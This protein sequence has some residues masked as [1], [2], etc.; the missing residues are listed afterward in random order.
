VLDLLVI[1]IV[2]ALA[3]MVVMWYGSLFA[4]SYLYT[5]PV[6]GISWRAPAA[7]GILTGFYLVWS[8]ANIWGATK[9]SV[10]VTEVPFGVFWQFSPRVEVI[11]QPVPE[12][13]SKRS[14]SEPALYELDKSLPPE[15]KYRKVDGEEYWSAVGTE[16]IEFKYRGEEYKFVRDKD[17]GD[18]PIVF[19][20]ANSGLEM[21][22]YEI[23]RVGYT[24]MTMLLVYFVLNALHFGL[25][26]GC[27]WV[28]LEFQFWH[29]VGLGFVLWFVATS[30]VLPALCDYAAAAC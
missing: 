17:R 24:S 2:F 28:L 15:T 30:A 3:L 29:A 8:L 20:D 23:G 25:W 11:P 26:I 27:L 13:V 12:F 4:Q 10:G 16:Y 22:E 19:V 7:A 5:T 1:L 9:T 18:N 21:N 14:N 6:S